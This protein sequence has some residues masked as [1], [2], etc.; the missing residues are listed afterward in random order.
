MAMIDIIYNIYI[1]LCVCVCVG[2][3]ACLLF[4]HKNRRRAFL[5]ARQNKKKLKTRVMVF[6]TNILLPYGKLTVCGK[7]P[8]YNELPEASIHLSREISMI[9]PWIFAHKN[10]PD[11]HLDGRGLKGIFHILRHNL[12]PLSVHRTDP[13]CRC[14]S[15]KDFSKVTMKWILE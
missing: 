11:N 12:Q 7:L 10:L 8:S 9:F 1:S 2:G 4:H 14:L 3:C 13:R 15:S 6:D 5:F